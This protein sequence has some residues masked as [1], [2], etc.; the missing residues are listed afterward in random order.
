MPNPEDTSFGA[1][2]E[3]EATEETTVSTP[4]VP[5]TE[6]AA[7]TEGGEPESE[8]LGILTEE[9]APEEEETPDLDIDPDLEKH[10]VL[11]AKWEAYKAQK[12]KGINKFLQSHTEKLKPLEEFKSE[13]EPVMEFVQSLRDPEQ[14]ES[15]VS[16]LLETLSQ[17]HGRSFGGP[18]QAQEA[19]DGE[20]VSKYGLEFAS[21]DKVVDVV[22]SQVKSL[23]EPITKK[24]ESESQTQAIQ[25][26][27]QSA[28]TLLKGEFEV[29]SD[30][31]ITTDMVTAAIRKHPTLE[32]SE[33]FAA[34][35]VKEIA[36]Y[37][38]K[39]S[40]GRKQE[41]RNM[42]TGLTGGKTR[43]DLNYGAGFGDILMSEATL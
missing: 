35:Y 22:L 33:A 30:P 38:A 10:P 8:T 7:P 31:W 28:T 5:E 27:A 42:P 15:A 40:A 43:A 6:I 11:K 20:P 9:E 19:Q 21:D 39:H 36:K 14:V 24:F 4:E 32:P 41:V 12:E 1:I 26:K 25:T 34:M 29:S 3:S 17:L 13:A 18:V 16:Q 37:T 23:M 2:L